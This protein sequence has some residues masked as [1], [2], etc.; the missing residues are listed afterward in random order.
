MKV[1]FVSS[2]NSKNGIS[3][4]ILSQANSLIK[5]GVDV[6]FYLIKGKG[7]I[8][9][10]SNIYPLRRKIKFI[11]PDI[12]HAH[13]SLTALI[14][15]IVKSKPL[16]VSLMGSDV[17]SSNKLKF[18]IRFFS[19]FSWNST[20][21]KSEDMKTSI[22]LME[23][24]V[25]PNGVDID[26]FFPMDKTKCQ[27]ALN[28]EEHKTHILFAAN[29]IRPEKQ[30]SLFEKAINLIN[31]G[32]I[33][34]HSL[35]DI[36]HSEIPIYLNASDVVVLTSKWEGSPNI[37]KESMSC[38]RP[39]VA[40][41]VGDIEWL[42]GNTDGHYLCCSNI[43][44]IAKQINKA[45]SYSKSLNITNGRERIMELQIDADSISKKIISL[46]SNIN[47]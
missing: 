31:K 29:P 6:E 23:A 21:V 24:K 34:V 20:I 19:K 22:N 25:I 41:K 13:F 27:D 42:F 5:N 8:G 35:I 45:I 40:T 38:N 3:P 18:L 2:G 17:K 10:I 44:D 16:I 36:E 7:I 43:I 39:I 4:I 30:Y 14:V 46:Y 11:S 32:N 28:W 33:V 12:I 47:D 37:I 9:Y 26:M 1:L 15:S